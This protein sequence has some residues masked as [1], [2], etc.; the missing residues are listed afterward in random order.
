M[1]RVLMLLTNQQQVIMLF[2]LPR[3]CEGQDCNEHLPLA[4]ENY[5]KYTDLSPQDTFNLEKLQSIQHTCFTIQLN[6]AHSSNT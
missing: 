1:K 3:V 5:S 2:L 4:V 6:H